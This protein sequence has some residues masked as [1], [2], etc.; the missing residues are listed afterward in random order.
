MLVL[1]CVSPDG[2]LGDQRGQDPAAGLDTARAEYEA[3]NAKELRTFSAAQC[4]RIWAATLECGLGSVPLDR[5]SAPVDAAVVAQAAE[6]NDLLRHQKTAIPWDHV[7]QW[8]VSSFWTAEQGLPASSP[9]LK[10]LLRY[11]GRIGEFCRDHACHTC[12]YPSHVY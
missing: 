8:E 9:Y 2:R 12:H 5:S 4:N 10:A 6:R 3:L 11:A 1:C 7:T